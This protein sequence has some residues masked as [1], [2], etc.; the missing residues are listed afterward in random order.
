MHSGSV[1]H[2][3]SLP[4]G[5]V[6]RHIRDIARTVARHHL[7]WH[8]AAT[9]DVIESPA[10]RRFF[11]IDRDILA[12]SPELLAQWLRERGVGIVHAHSVARPVRERAS[13]AMRSLGVPS[14]VTLHDVLF[15]RPDFESR[16]P[17]P[18]WLCETEPFI[19]A[20]SA[21]VAP[22]DYLADVARANLSGI[23]VDVIPNGS[24]SGS[25]HLSRT[26]GLTP[27]PVPGLVVAVVGA[28]G[29]HKG[30]RLLEE[31]SKRLEGSDIYIVVIGYLDTQIT[32]GWHSDHLYIHGT[33]QDEEVAPLLAAYG[34]R[35]ALFPN[36]VPESFS[37][38]LSDVWAAGVP[39]LVA[40]DGALGERVRRH[41]GGW[42]LPEG[43][44][45]A[46]VEA[47]LRRLLAPQAG[48]ELA[49]VKS[50]LAVADDGR[51]PPLDAMA[52]SLDA[53]YTRFGL[54][55]RAPVDAA[56]APAQELIAKNLDGAMFRA[57]L[58]RLADEMDQMKAA[59]EGSLEFER[60][61]KRK[62]DEESD[63]WIA[64][65]QGDVAGLQEELRKEFE[66]RCQYSKELDELRPLRNTLRVKLARAMRRIFNARS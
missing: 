28:I 36:A 26:R 44:G 12:S 23:G 61:Q 41:G 30:A 3:T 55:P 47:E 20:A 59:H 48:P 49:R 11:P 18:A 51:T 24:D 16:A 54:D 34:A 1:L 39:A 7:I 8:T 43:F 37:Y 64:K 15:L 33:Y 17:D 31:L 5:G 29:P 38:T 19:R 6:D 50:Q 4:G 9:A 25:D 63:R 45:A 14:L 65:L 46:D 56:S 32:S 2:V 21:V 58:A 13:W 35:L 53:L 66:L 57:E 22:S 60:G 52:R 62:A 40:P 42:L 10:E 27:N